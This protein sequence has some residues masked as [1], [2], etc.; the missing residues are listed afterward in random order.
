MWTD[1]SERPLT[2]VV[3]LTLHDEGTMWQCEFGWGGSLQ[4]GNEGVH[5][6]GSFG[7][8]SRV[9]YKD[10]CPFD[11]EGDHSSRDLAAAKVG[12]SDLVVPRGR[13]II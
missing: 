9:E 10:I 1:T 4:K 2:K 7:Q 8:S 3:E 5:K 12:P 13:A 11:C 6:M